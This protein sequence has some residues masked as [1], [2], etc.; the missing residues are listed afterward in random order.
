MKKI[1]LLVA[2]AFTANVINAQFIK[3]KSISAQIGVGLS[4][5]NNSTADFTDY[6]FFLQGELI[7]E[8][9]DWI[10]LRPYAG[11]VSTSPAG[12]DFDGNPINEFATTKALLLGGKA[13]VRAPIRWVAPYFEIGIG[14]SIG[15]F[16]TSTDFDNISRSGIIYHVPVSLGLELGRNNNFD[17]GFSYYLQPSVEQFTGAFAIGITFSLK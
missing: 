4:A 16:E 9:S 15:S 7:L 5:P 6:G 2:V 3:K 10:E 13:R 17:L 11:Y 14:T 12:E 1:L 8:V